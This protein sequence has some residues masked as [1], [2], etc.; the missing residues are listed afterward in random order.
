MAR[1]ELENLVGSVEPVHNFV[2]EFSK[3]PEVFLSDNKK[4]PFQ[5]TNLAGNP[6]YAEVQE[7]LESLVQEHMD[8]TGDKFLKG[9]DYKQFYDKENVRIKALG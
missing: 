9:T 8:R 1:L 7:R 4:D 6:D 5:Q 3:E 2:D